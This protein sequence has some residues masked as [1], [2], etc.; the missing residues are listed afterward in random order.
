[1][2]PLMLGNRVATTGF[3][4]CIASISVRSSPCSRNVGSTNTSSAL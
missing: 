3:P 4:H 2:L 1:M